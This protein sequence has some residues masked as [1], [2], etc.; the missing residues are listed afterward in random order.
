MDFDFSF[1]ISDEEMERLKKLL[2]A[3]ELKHYI[4]RTYD[5]KQLDV[6]EYQEYQ[7]IEK[8]NED[9][10]KRLEKKYEKVGTLTGEILY[11][12]NTR[13]ANEITVL[14]TENQKLNEQMEYKY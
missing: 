12:E 11:E 14:K 10:K 5:N 7:K 6:V 4:V 2:T 3:S 8:E 1:D 9:L 13:F